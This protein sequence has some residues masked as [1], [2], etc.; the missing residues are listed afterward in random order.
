MSGPC[1]CGA[2]DCPRCFPGC[3]DTVSL[4]CKC[5]GQMPAYAASICVECGADVCEDCRLCADC[6]DEIGEDP[7]TEQEGSDG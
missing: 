6:A 1:D 4:A 7:E 5:G 3:L 2:E